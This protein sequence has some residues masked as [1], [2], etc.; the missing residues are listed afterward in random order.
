VSKLRRSI[1][2]AGKVTQAGRVS[3]EEPGKMSHNEEEGRARKK[4]A[5]FPRGARSKIKA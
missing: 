4:F 3:A 5:N 2:A 1:A